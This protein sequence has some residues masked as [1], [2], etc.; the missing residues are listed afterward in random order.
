VTDTPSAW[1]PTRARLVA[2]AA[3][4]ALAP[5]PL[6]AAEATPHTPPT[7]DLRAAVKKA[8]ATTSLSPLR[9]QASNTPDLQSPSFFRTPLGI[10]VIA[11]VGSGAAYAV[12]SA[13]HDRIHSTAR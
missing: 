1:R 9:A 6:A 12:Y 11:V 7:I 5:M 10:A 8:A 3:V 4:L 2:I 13:H